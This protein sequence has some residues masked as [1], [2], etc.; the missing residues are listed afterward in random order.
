MSARELITCE[1]LMAWKG[2]NAS[3]AR[4]LGVTR[5]AISLAR[6]RHRIPSPR[7]SLG[8]TV[9]NAV[10]SEAE[11]SCTTVTQVV[12]DLSVWASKID[13]GDE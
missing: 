10:L 8:R 12:S 9:K 5:A 1:T 11:R 3:L 13:G 2:T 6:K 4:A 7:K